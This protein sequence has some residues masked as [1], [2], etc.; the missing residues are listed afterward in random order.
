M[1]KCKYTRDTAI[2]VFTP[3]CCLD[4]DEY[5][6]QTVHEEDMLSWFYSELKAK[7]EAARWQP[8][9]TA[10]MDGTTI[11]LGLPVCG[12]LWAEDRRVYEGRWHEREGTWTSIN[13]FIL[14]S[15]ATHWMPLPEPPSA[16]KGEK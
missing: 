10:P 11:L 4:A 14:F 6:Y 3:E 2:E 1:S 5:P 8:I 15:V 9:E 7:L 12:N 13:G 16:I